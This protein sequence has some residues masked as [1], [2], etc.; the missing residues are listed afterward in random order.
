MD[1][2]KRKSKAFDMFEVETKG[3]EKLPLVPKWIFYVLISIPFILPNLVFSGLNW[4]DTLHLLKWFTALVP[5]ALLL[6]VAGVRLLRYG[7]E[8]MAFVIDP[9]GWI[10]FI[11]ILF[12]TFQP[13]LAP[14]KTHVTFVKEW[15]FFASLWGAYI[16]CYNLFP[17]GPFHRFIL[18]G[19]NLN[20]VMNIFFAEL[21]IR[22]LNA[23]FPF[24]LPTPG[25]YIGNTGQQEM[26]GLWIA[27]ALLNALY[28]YWVYRGEKSKQSRTLSWL[29]LIVVAICAWG[30]WNSTTLGAMLALAVATLVF[31]TGA[32]RQR[33]FQSIKPFFVLCLILFL[34]LAATFGVGIF[35]KTGRMEALVAK[36]TSV[37]KDVKTI[38]GRDSIWATGWTMFTM[39]P[40]TGV[41][42]GHF[43]WNYLDA[44]REM[45][46]RHPAM[47]WQYTYW[48]HNELIQWFDETGIFGGLAL[49]A[50][51]VWW[52]LR[53]IRETRK[54]RALPPEVIWAGSMVFLLW[55]DA[56]FSRPF[57]RIENA[58]WLSLAFAL[59]NRH[60]LPCEASW[61]RVNHPQ[62][63]RV[64]GS[65]IALISLLGLLF[66]GDGM[67]GDKE[68]LKGVAATDPQ[69]QES[70]LEAAHRHLMT[71][72]DAEQ[73]LAYHYLLLAESTHNGTYLSEGLNRLYAYFLKRPHSKDLM[74]LLQWTERL[75]QTDKFKE[76]LTYMQAAN[77]VPAKIRQ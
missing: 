8:K 42:L 11:F 48:A 35:L 25:N 70:Y 18:W 51:G 56:M 34:A 53:Y 74:T 73:Q 21:Q 65:L 31:L 29:N 15:F 27:M 37:L 30:L 1:D 9:F 10:W 76:L 67:V 55:A 39:H 19:A 49:V 45:L 66:L 62:F 50:L 71:R 32:I 33:G 63:F 28:L 16:L 54:N 59:A 60:I 17:E 75:G 7:T 41:G 22:G 4:F 2:K 36:T 12:L 24:I 58:L 61:T 72:D 44:Q 68:L 6:I 57:H 20:A 64:L 38:D 46:Q 52:L 69:V 14:I 77:G 23:P 5:L 43:K 26:F 47:L 3:T 13:F 40:V